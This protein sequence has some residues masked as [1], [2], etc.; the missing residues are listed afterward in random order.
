MSFYSGGEIKTRFI[1]P[2]NY[3]PNS[4][5]EFRLDALPVILSNMRIADLGVTGTAHA[6]NHYNKLTGSYGL[7]KNIRLMDGQTEL[8]SLREVGRYLGFKNLLLSNSKNESV[9]K[10]LNNS[11]LGYFIDET[12][13]DTGEQRRT[14]FTQIDTTSSTTNKGHLDLRGVLPL[15]NSVRSLNNQLF[16]KLR[17]VIEFETIQ[18]KFLNKDNIADAETLRPV[19]IV[20]EVVDEGV[21]NN[22]MKNFPNN[23]TWLEVEHDSIQIPAVPVTA[24]NVKVE[25]TVSNRVRGFDNKNLQRL[26]VL[27]NNS[28]ESKYVNA[29]VNSGCG[30]M[31]SQAQYQQKINYV[32]N[33]SNILTGSG[34]DK[35]AS[36]LA[37]VCDSWGDLN[38]VPI[39]STTDQEAISNINDATNIQGK[40]DY[41]GVYIGQDIKD[42][43][44]DFE[45][46]GVRNGGGDETGEV[47][48]INMNLYGEVM[49]NI[50]TK[51][52][53][54]NVVYA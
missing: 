33:G 35:P 42:L 28:N 38:L 11:S 51:G 52:N 10:M 44:I 54:Y 9:M 4:R 49:K 31:G 26:V 41:D 29:N 23:V 47:D 15:L 43:K 50:V 13:E 2:V 17:L 32:V 19:L 37:M 34:L 21:M 7:I 25:Q 14:S 53:E 40:K 30:N 45:R 8:S 46:V 27:K 39:E 24:G 18:Q 48:A 22:E 36:R 1:D 5:A 6:H 3:I 20:D 16:P 12:G